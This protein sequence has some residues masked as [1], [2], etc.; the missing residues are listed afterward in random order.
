VL[1]DRDKL[2][3]VLLNLLS[4]ALKFTLPGG[5]ITVT[6]RAEPGEP[7]TAVLEVA[8]T[9]IGIPEDKLETIFEP[10]VQIDRTLKNPAEGTGLGL[11][12]SRELAHGMGG[13]LSATSAPGAGSVS[14]LRLRMA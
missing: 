1:A 9:G 3:Q 6:L 11:A 8:D 4:N 12:V 10:F 7:G 2:Q 14:A 13:E 5:R